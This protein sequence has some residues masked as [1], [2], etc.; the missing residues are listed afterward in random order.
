MGST[1]LRFRHAW[2]SLALAASFCRA[3]SS[4]PVATEPIVTAVTV[5]N[6]SLLTI[7]SV[8]TSTQSPA[9]TAAAQSTVVTTINGRVT[10][11]TVQATGTGGAVAP[12]VVL[13]T[14][15]IISTITTEEVVMSTVG[16]STIFG[17]DPNLAVSV[18]ILIDQPVTMAED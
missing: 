18:P 1:I 7:Y 8:V 11:I 13:Q 12:E 15:T 5:P 17:A 4:I 9:T 6:T 3:Q 10:T 16:Y 14:N 2:W